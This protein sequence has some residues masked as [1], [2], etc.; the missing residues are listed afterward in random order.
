MIVITVPWFVF[1]FSQDADYKNL[2]FLLVIER[3][4]VLVELSY[5]KTIFI[6]KILI[7]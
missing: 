3:C 7:N 4:L 1:I 5:T 6:E 2:I